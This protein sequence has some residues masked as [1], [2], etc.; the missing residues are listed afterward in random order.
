MSAITTARSVV[1]H[2]GMSC[3][4]L[5][6][7]LGILTIRLRRLEPAA[8]RATAL[9]ARIDEQAL[10]INSLRDQLAAAKQIREDVDIRASRCT[11]AEMRAEKLQVELDG[12]MVELVALRQFKANVCSVSSLPQRDPANEV[13]APQGIDVRTLREAADAGLLGPVTGPGHVKAG[14]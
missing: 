3:L 14:Q 4:E 5:H 10:T 1:S 9:E 13:T 11:E 8:E 12:Q 7:K 2:R 6:R